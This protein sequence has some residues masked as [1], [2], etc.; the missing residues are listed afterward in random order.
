MVHRSSVR[1]SR[2]KS[3][4]T[5]IELLVVIAIIAVL[6]GLLLPAVQKVREAAARMQCQNNLKQLGLA[7]HNYHGVYSQFPPGAVK[8]RN[9]SPAGSSNLVEYDRYTWCLLLLPYI[10]MD[11]LYRNWPFHY[12]GPGAS[13][14]SVGIRSSG[15]F[16]LPATGDLA[17]GAIAAQ[18]V[19]TFL[20]PSDPGLAATSPYGVATD[21]N[22]KAKPGLETWSPTNGFQ[23]LPAGDPGYWQ[24]GVTSY[25]GN[26]GIATYGILKLYSQCAICDGQNDSRDG[27]I[28]LSQY[29]NGNGALCSAAQ[30]VSGTNNID[31]RTP[32]SISSIPD[33]TS[34]TLLLGEKSLWDPG[35]AASCTGSQNMLIDQSFWANPSM[36]DCV[37]G[38]EFPL[39]SSFQT[40]LG[41]MTAAGGCGGPPGQGENVSGTDPTSCACDARTVNFS[42]NHTGGVNF[43]FCDGSVH[44]VSQSIP[45]VILQALST[46][47]GGETITNTSSF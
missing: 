12:Y 9:Y 21:L 37:A 11:N 25:H 15:T 27:V 34:N 24:W 29:F 19:K 40:L 31:C 41:L 33:G 18:P 13:G 45:L 6:I 26:G 30:G 36:Q 39:N 22:N 46:R 3:A 14:V 16:T 8:F 35:Y 4:F 38:T 47:A 42:S 5:L 10:E 1:G 17:T 32:V 2:S 44:F 7:A 43:V 20:C 28:L 23:P